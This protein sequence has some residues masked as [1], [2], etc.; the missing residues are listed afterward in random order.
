MRNYRFLI[1]LAII[2]VLG[3][4]LYPLK[5]VKN[6]MYVI[7]S[8]I[9]GGLNNIT[10]SIGG[11]FSDLGSIGKLSHENET[12]TE[13]NNLLE[14]E[15]VELKEYKHENEILKQELDFVG[16]KREKELIGAKIISRE[17][18]PYLQNILIDKGKKDGVKEGQILMSQGYLVGIISQLFD[19]YSQAE[20][21]TS[22]QTLIPV[23]L[24]ETRAT[25][26]LKSQLEGLYIE[27]IPVD[28]EIKKDESVL[29]SNLSENIPQDIPIGKVDEV[30]KHESEIFQT[31]KVKSPIEFSK[32]E[33]VFIVK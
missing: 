17:I 12:L 24:Q 27:D 29:T 1:I 25:G 16:N 13:K 4:I 32:L 6:F 5:P 33:F 21:I 8:P 15:V 26:L 14:A 30:T 19:D 7:S 28:Q 3:I 18:S 9:A 20:L 10:S 2:L 11:F 31:I 22:S 23:I